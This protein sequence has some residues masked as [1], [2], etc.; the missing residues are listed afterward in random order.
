[1][2]GVC[3]PLV[4]PSHMLVPLS[5]SHVISE[6][7]RFNFIIHELKPHIRLK[8]NAK[9]TSKIYYCESGRCTRSLLSFIMEYDWLY[10]G[11]RF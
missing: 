3:I 6:E 10:S 4:L 8:H 1:M 5:F 7:K 11:N 2:S 9:K